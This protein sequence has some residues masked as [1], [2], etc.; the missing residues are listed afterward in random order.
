MSCEI[1]SDDVRFLAASS[2]PEQAPRCTVAYEE[3]CEHYGVNPSA[4]VVRKPRPKGTVESAVAYVKGSAMVN[5]E[6]GSVSQ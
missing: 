5:F 1:V 4:T 3:L 6:I 2:T